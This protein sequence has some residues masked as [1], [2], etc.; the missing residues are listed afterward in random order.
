MKD[1]KQHKK[2][3]EMLTEKVSVTYN[4]MGERRKH[5]IPLDDSLQVMSSDS[6]NYFYRKNSDG[7]MMESR[8][9]ITTP[10]TLTNKISINY[11]ENPLN[12]EN[13]L[14]FHRAIK[15][16]RDLFT[17][18]TNIWDTTLSLSGQ[19]A[20]PRPTLL[21]V[22]TCQFTN[23]YGN[24]K[25][26]T[27][28]RMKNF[29][30]CICN[31]KV[32][33]SLLRI[34]N[35]CGLGI[36]NEEDDKLK[37]DLLFLFLHI[38]SRL[39][40]QDYIKQGKRL[41]A[42]NGSDRTP[43]LSD[44]EQRRRRKSSTS[45]MNSIRSHI[46]EKKDILSS[47]HETALFKMS[48]KFPPLLYQKIQLYLD[49]LPRCTTVV[50][51]NEDREYQEE[52][53]LY[54]NLVDI[55]DA[56]EGIIQIVE[57]FEEQSISLRSQL[58]GENILLPGQR[59]CNASE[60]GST[61][62]NES[63]TGN[64][65]VSTSSGIDKN[66]EESLQHLNQ[67]VD[68][69][70]RN[71]VQRSGVLPKDE[72]D[73]IFMTW[74]WS[75]NQNGQQHKGNDKNLDTLF[76]KYLH[77][78]NNMI[79][80]LNIVSLIYSQIFVIGHINF[81]G[82]CKKNDNVLYLDRAQ[83]EKLFLYSQ[84]GIPES[85]Q[86]QWKSLNYGSVE[87]KLTIT[88]TKAIDILNVIP[89]ISIKHGKIGTKSDCE[90]FYISQSHKYGL[91][92]GNK[93]RTGSQTKSYITMP[94][95]ATVEH[96]K[97]F[98][99]QAKT[100]IHVNDL[101][102]TGS[103]YSEHCAN[104]KVS[105]SAKTAK[106]AD[107]TIFSPPLKKTELRLESKEKKFISI[108]QQDQNRA[109]Y[110][111]PNAN[112]DIRPCQAIV[113][114]IDDMFVAMSKTTTSALNK[115]QN[116][117]NHHGLIEMKESGN[118]VARITA[119]YDPSNLKEKSW[120]ESAIEKSEKEETRQQLPVL[121]EDRLMSDQ[122]HNGRS[123][124][125]A[126][127]GINYA[128]S[129]EDNVEDYTRQQHEGHHDSKNEV[130]RNT[131]PVVGDK[132][133]INTLKDH[134]ENLNQKVKQRGI[135][136]DT[137]ATINCKENILKESLENQHWLSK[138]EI[139][140]LETTETD[141]IMDRDDFKIITNNN[142]KE[143]NHF[144]G[145]PKDI[146]L[147]KKA[148]KICT[149][150]AGQ[151][152]HNAF[153]NEELIQT[154][155]PQK[156]LTFKSLNR[157][158]V[159]KDKNH[160]GQLILC[161]TNQENIE[162]NKIINY[163][164]V[165]NIHFLQ[166]GATSQEKE[167]DNFSRRGINQQKRMIT[168]TAATKI[169]N[170]VKRWILLPIQAQQN[171]PI[172]KSSSLST[173]L[174]SEHEKVSEYNTM[175]QQLSHRR[176]DILFNQIESIKKCASIDPYSK[177]E[178]SA[179]SYS[180]SEHGGFSQYNAIEQQPSHQSD[181]S[182]NHNE[183][184]NK[185]ESLY[186]VAPPKRGS[187]ASSYL[188]NEHDLVIQ[189][190]TI[191]QP[192][193]HQRNGV[194][195]NQNEPTKAFESNITTC[196][197]DSF[198]GH[199]KF[200]QNNFISSKQ[201]ESVKTLE[202]NNALGSSKRGWSTPT[203]FSDEHELVCQYK[204]IDQPSHHSVV[205]VNQNGP[206]KTFGSSSLSNEN[207]LVRQY[208]IEKQSSHQIYGVSCNQNE[209][210]KTFESIYALGSCI[211]G[212]SASS[213]SSTECDIVSQ[214]DTIKQRPSRQ[215]NGISPNPN[216]STKTFKLTYSK[217]KKQQKEN[218]TERSDRIRKMEVNPQQQIIVCNEKG[219]DIYSYAIKSMS[220][221]NGSKEQV[222]VCNE[223]YHGCRYNI[224]NMSSDTDFSSSECSDTLD[225]AP[226]DFPCRDE[227]KGSIGERVF[228]SDD[229]P[230]YFLKEDSATSKQQND[231]LVLGLRKS[232]HQFS[233]NGKVKNVLASGTL[234]RHELFFSDV[235]DND[236]GSDT[237]TKLVDSYT[238]DNGCNNDKQDNDFCINIHLTVVDSWDWEVYF[239]NRTRCSHFLPIQPRMI[240]STEGAPLKYHVIKVINLRE[241]IR[242]AELYLWQQRIIDLRCKINLSRAKIHGKKNQLKL[243]KSKKQD[244]LSSEEKR[245]I[246]CFDTE[247][248]HKVRYNAPKICSFPLNKIH[249]SENTLVSDILQPVTYKLT[250]KC[251]YGRVG[252]N[253]E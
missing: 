198:N 131:M 57:D 153:S 242:T 183:S 97:R 73:D 149:R 228:N 84:I 46:G 14:E 86:Q 161:N 10:R 169:Q 138:R 117:K 173:Y 45:V 115:R 143:E 185:N 121:S 192:T 21:D 206:T 210:T 34:A 32:Y 90:G 87:S 110:I 141:C 170:Y 60:Q 24:V 132:E 220:S 195:S 189:R 125:K 5:S 215:R 6:S 154:E 12:R 178:S 251:R 82:L 196:S 187:L 37:D 124:Q 103:I 150:S 64:S 168:H 156:R 134:S 119:A 224:R 20:S 233:N 243:R 174:T 85:R 237:V 111:Q 55:E 104:S 232:F 72:W 4:S 239:N 54:S 67:L 236:A 113:E 204:A 201:N 137:T 30:Q 249:K 164:V 133:D 22:L 231:L 247:D 155:Q 74:R 78:N 75:L 116:K 219:K 179:L 53:Q 3:K 19:S 50:V 43:L 235:K 98:R 44:N 48:L 71:D 186:A 212:S 94:H 148:I 176:N 207:E 184:T 163:N 56:L 142:Q 253:L 175:K 41:N 100:E 140:N 1:R 252:Q 89:S 209:S 61:A 13:T 83:I 160:Y 250:R 205:S 68:E 162:D 199:E 191:E 139:Y 18:Y 225:Q 123:M 35:R 144:D 39:Y 52:E 96:E 51:L 214:Y 218:Q 15:T 223:N 240:L 182:F 152:N 147:N 105:K 222:I 106:I 81:D 33:S 190:K 99:H 126:Q 171:N 88:N 31:Q 17:V 165:N 77:K 27:N 193:S 227:E 108:L 7:S 245:K 42:G 246:H 208:K 226:F 16:L 101:S 95:I 65:M 109:Q 234:D 114:S 129:F 2:L 167:Y 194:S 159:N 229:S 188:S 93:G 49:S 200:N 181:I 120:S 172:H 211:I 216:G 9:T 217:S 157:G 203:Y 102:Y 79:A 23:L 180:S 107:S 69:L 244:Q 62:S 130:T 145:S 230:R 91:K 112:D 70:L 128:N 38:R 59:L 25:H 166:K 40:G 136:F 80:Y 26:V 213:Y 158:F 135:K 127:F 58:F 197:S 8:T 146:N 202:P 238:R 151:K 11:N 28:Q 92:R 47:F 36:E 177:S 63:N 221:D 76:E 118:T 248:H 29:K 241:L 66:I 122:F